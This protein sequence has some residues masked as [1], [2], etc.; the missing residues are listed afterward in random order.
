MWIRWNLLLF[1]RKNG[2]LPLVIFNINNSVLFFS[3][4]N[5]RGYAERSAS[6]ATPPFWLAL[7]PPPPPPMHGAQQRF[8]LP[9]PS[10]Y[11]NFIQHGEVRDENGT[12]RLQPEVSI[13][14]FNRLIMGATPHFSR[15]NFERPIAVPEQGIQLSVVNHEVSVTFPQLGLLKQ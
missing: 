3:A 12:V 1:S 2:T 5:Q 7:P 4:W 13:R 11:R 8:F 14:P 9:R 15:S 10:I 6:V